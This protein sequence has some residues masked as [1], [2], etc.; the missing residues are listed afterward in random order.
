MDD[1]LLRTLFTEW[2]ANGAIPIDPSIAKRLPLR[3]LTL[4]RALCGFRLFMRVIWVIRGLTLWLR[5]RRAAPSAVS[6]PLSLSYAID[7]AQ[8]EVIGESAIPEPS[9]MG[10]AILACVAVL[11]A[12]PRPTLIV[13][14]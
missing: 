1:L 6:C 13:A 3:T 9:N 11:F 8:L 2:S 10:Y 14:A 12:R 4:L 5:L 7:Y